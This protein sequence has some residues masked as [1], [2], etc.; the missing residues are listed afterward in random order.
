MAYYRRRLARI[1]AT[2][3]TMF[4]RA[5]AQVLQA[6]PAG[7]VLDVGCGAGDLAELLEGW[8]YTGLDASPDM[9]ALAR[10]RYPHARFLQ[11]DARELPDGP[12]NA[13]VA[14]GEVLNYATDLPGFIA[15]VAAAR[16]R[17]QPG[18][19]LLVDLAGPTRADPQPRT[20]VQQGED[21]R[22]EVTVS[23]DPHRQTLTRVITI[24]DDEGTET[25]THV[26]HLMDPVDVVAALR[27]AGFDVT[28]LNGY[29]EELP[30]PR[31][32]SGFLGRVILES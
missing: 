11:A 28:A 8:E 15:W 30:F 7:S 31:G 14:V 5:A 23:T 10:H 26:L 24:T 3:Y 29:S 21:Y 16:S 2:D 9:I 12:V 22:I 17:L 27:N 6:E 13:I 20:T 18:G 19:I 1:H 32:W 4:A 25:E